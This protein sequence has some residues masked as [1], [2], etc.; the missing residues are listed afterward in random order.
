MRAFLAIAA[1]LLA[2]ERRE[3][4]PPAPVLPSEQRAPA[5]YVARQAVP[6]VVLPPMEGALRLE[7]GG[8][9]ADVRY[10]FAVAHGGRTFRVY[11]STQ[12]KNCAWAEGGGI[13]VIEDDDVHVDFDVVA[14][15]FQHDGTIA[16]S[17]VGLSWN[18]SSRAGWSGANQGR[19]A[20]PAEVSP[21]GDGCDRRIR[22]SARRTE[23]SLEGDFVATCCTPGAPPPPDPPPMTARVG[24]EE[25]ALL[26]A[27]A[28]PTDSGLQFRVSRILETCRSNTTHEDLYLEVFTRGPDLEVHGISAHGMVLP[29]LGISTELGL[30]HV[31]VRASIEGERLTLEGRAQL[32]DRFNS[33][34]PSLELEVRG[35][36]PIVRC[37]ERN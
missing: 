16:W 2:C 15:L 35:A 8:R 31:P 4:R 6:P 18:G 27:S 24:G 14:P 17:V 13:G 12:P 9:S 22:L 7:T 29:H 19:L 26:R 5:P 28:T 37:P 3:P 11:S 34:A 21:S 33:R 1:V 25:F 20:I 36:V 32:G 10:A 23:F 30:D